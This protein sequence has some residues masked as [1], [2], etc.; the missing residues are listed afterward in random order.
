MYS[1]NLV[2]IG[3]GISI[4]LIVLGFIALLKQKTYIDSKT[5]QPT[6]IKLPFF[7]EM[8]TNFPALIFV[9]SAIVTF[10]TTIQKSKLEGVTVWHIEGSI[11]NPKNKN[12]DWSKSE[13]RMMPTSIINDNID[14]CG[15]F[16]IDVSIANG[17]RMEDEIEWIKYSLDASSV[18]IQPQ[19]AANEKDSLCK[20]VDESI[21]SRK[22]KVTPD[23]NN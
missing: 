18:T 17:E 11:K 20:L 5:Q 15:D 6:K 14:S 1:K 23:Y 7:G 19:K 8:V 2:L 13:L 3:L 12:L 22:Y 4:L 9:F 21:Y 16:F 10:Y